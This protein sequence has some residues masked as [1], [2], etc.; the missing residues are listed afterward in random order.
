MTPRKDL[1]ELI[2]SLTEREANAFRKEIGK[3]KGRHLYLEVFEA[4]LKMEEYDE[5][6]LKKRFSGS[7]TLNNFS[8]AKNNLYEKILEV[9]AYLPYHQNIETTL[10]LFRQQITILVKKSLHEQALKRISKAIRIAENHEAYNLLTDLYDLQREITREYLSPSD[11]LSIQRELRNKEAWVREVD[12]NLQQ[13]KEFFDKAS[14]APKAPVHIRRTLINSILGHHMMEN[15]SECQSV[16]AKLYFYRIWKDLYAL[17]GKEGWHFFTEKI[18]DL[19]EENPQMLEDAGKLLVYLN[20]F[21]DLG[22]NYITTRNFEKAE[23]IAESLQKMRIGIKTGEGEALVFSRYWK[24][25]VSLHQEKP[26]QEEGLLTVEAI[27]KGLRKFKTKISK[28]DEMELVHLVGVFLLSIERPAEA[29]FWILQL[30]EARLSPNRPD[31]HFFNWLL[32]LMAHYNRNNFDVIEQQLPGTINYLES[33][34]PLSAYETEVLNF[35]KKV[36][37]AVDESERK[38]LLIKLRDGIKKL[39]FAS[40]SDRLQGYFNILAWIDSRIKGIPMIEVLGNS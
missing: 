6:S 26:D 30:R 28:K 38:E 2:H 27:R 18:L 22:L 13:Y 40:D 36:I 23:E 4:I 24:I 7:K 12:K 16:S 20:T 33:H 32:F 19:F 1:F 35:F 25:M 3:R 34:H 9:V 5:R 14:I 8:I 10:Y 11:F 17:Q 31:L 37:K 39:F 21:S 29:L 15:V